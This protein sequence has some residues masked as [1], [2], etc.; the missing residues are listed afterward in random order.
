LDKEYPAIPST[1]NEEDNLNFD[2]LYNLVVLL[3]QQYC[4][5]F[6]DEPVCLKPIA[7]LN[8]IYGYALMLLKSSYMLL[9]SFCYEINAHDPLSTHVNIKKS[10][11]GRIR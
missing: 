5:L 6:Y 2:D 9:F 4:E 8:S 1:T 3:L 10:S 11:V 7:L